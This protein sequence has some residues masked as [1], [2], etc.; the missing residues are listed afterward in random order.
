[1]T[2]FGV[3]GFRFDLMGHHMRDNML[4]VRAM[5]DSLTPEADGVDGTQIYVY[6]EG[7]NFGE[8]ADNARGINATQLNMAGTGIGTFN[9]RLRDAAR[10]GN[11]FGG[12]QEQGFINGLY[13]DPNEVETRAPEDQQ[14]L[15]LHFMDQIRV[16]LAG[17]LADYPLID[18]T[19]AQVTGADIDYNGQPT[20]YTLDPQEHIVYVSAHDNETLFDAIQLKAPLTADADLR[21]RMQTMGQS[22]VMFAQGVPF[23]H[24][25]DELL[26]SKSLDRN[27]YNSGD[28]YNALDWTMAGNNWGHG[29]P[30]EGDNGDRWDIMQ[31]LLADPALAVT[32]EQIARTDALFLELLQIRQGSPLFRLRTA[33]DIIARVSFL[34]EGPNALPGLIVMR[35]SDTV[36]D[37]LD[38]NASEI[39]VVFNAT[40]DAQ[41]I[42]VG[43]LAAL[44]FALHPVQQASADPVVQSATVGDVAFFVPA[45]TTAVFV[46]P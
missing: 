35:L 28:W 44:G 42:D 21:A 34:N 29:L 27:S 37:D 20:G 17:N 13:T 2:E 5:L 24:A 14:M 25:G 12:W 39:I 45:M 9:D 36:G 38:P 41:T 15:L 46:A 31:P 43:E 33:E 3:Q 30:L 23:F 6:G 10:G 16:G 8:V 22:L 26:R 11:P 7:W 19:G 40:A 1:V 18:A 4:N 32:T